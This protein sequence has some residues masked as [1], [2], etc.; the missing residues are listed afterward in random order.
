MSK[1]AGRLLNA[2]LLAVIFLALAVA[3]G[4]AYD[5]EIDSVAPEAATTPTLSGAAGVGNEPA[6]GAAKTRGRGP[7]AVSLDTSSVA[8]GLNLASR[9]TSTTAKWPT[10][11][12]MRWQ[13]PHGFLR[14]A[15]CV[16]RHESVDWYR[17]YVDWRGYPSRY[18][19]GLQFTL[20]TWRRAGGTGHAF[21]W[22][23]REQVY[24]AYVI[25]RRNGGS[26]REWGTAGRCGLR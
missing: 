15:F 22:R 6:S 8:P 11:A 19:G 5:Y 9:P 14:A 26:W 10:P 4:R 16:H 23:P 7:S 12:A 2:A 21:E 17:A 24:R 1:F 20:S 25:W 18:S 13:P 3:S